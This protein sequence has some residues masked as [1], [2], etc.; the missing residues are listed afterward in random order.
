[1]QIKAAVPRNFAKYEKVLKRP[2]YASGLEQWEVAVR[3]ME[4]WLMARLAWMD[5]AFQGAGAV[6]KA[7]GP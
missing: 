4:R 3:E 5:K 2:E 6:A 1:M 7:D